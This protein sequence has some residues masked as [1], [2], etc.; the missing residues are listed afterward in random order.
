MQRTVLATM[1]V[2]FGAGCGDQGVVR[3]RPRLALSPQYVDFGGVPVALAA[4]QV[5]RLSN[6]GET[7]LQWQAD[8]VAGVR[9]LSVSRPAGQLRSGESTALEVRLLAR[10]SG[11]LS[12]HL[13]IKTNNPDQPEVLVPVRGQVTPEVLKVSPGL[14]AFGPVRVGVGLQRYVQVQNMSPDRVRLAISVAPPAEGLALLSDAFVVLPAYG[15]LQVDLQYIPDAVG[16]MTSYLHI[17]GDCTRPCQERLAVSGRAVPSSL[18]C[19]PSAVDFSYTNLESCSHRTVACENFGT[20]AIRLNELELDAPDSGMSVDHPALPRT[21]EPGDHVDLELTY[22]PDA[23]RVSSAQ[24]NLHVSEG[25]GQSTVATVGLLGT[26]GGPNISVQPQRIYFG[27]TALGATRVR[28][29]TVLNVGNA[30]LTLSGHHFEPGAGPF[31]WLAPAGPARILA[32]SSMQVSLRFRADTI[33]PLR[34]E[35]VLL[36]DDPDQPETRITLDAE[37][38]EPGRCTA[39]LQPSAY[40]FGLVDVGQTSQATITLSAGATPCRWSDPRV[41]GDSSFRLSHIFARSGEVPAGA[42]VAF[43]IEYHAGAPSSGP[44][45]SA[46]FTIDVPHAQPDE[47]QVDLTAQAT[48]HDLLIWPASIDFGSRQ[49]G[50]TALRALFVF[51]TGTARHVLSTFD[52]QALGLELRPPPAPIHLNPGESLRIDLLWTPQVPALMQSTLS[53]RSNTLPA[54]LRVQIRGNA[55][56]ARCGRLRA[57]ICAPHGGWP[58]VG[59]QVKI[60]TRGGQEFTSE[61]DES[62]A[63]FGSCLPEGPVTVEVTQGHYRASLVGNVYLDRM[64]DLGRVCLSGP[65]AAQ[66]A[67]ISGIYDDVQTVLDAAEVNY[68]VDPTGPGADRLLTDLDLLLSFDV[69]LLACGFPDAL[70]RDPQVAQNLRSFVLQGGSL[71]VSDLGYNALEAAWPEA[72]DFSGDDSV[73]DAANAGLG[74]PVVL[75]ARVLEPEVIRLVGSPRFDVA[76]DLP[77]VRVESTHRSATVVAAARTFGPTAGLKPLA[78]VYRP[79]ATS[80][81]VVFTTVHHH[82]Q[83]SE[84]VQRILQ[85]LI[86]RL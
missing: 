58:A 56:S 51:N 17:E 7:L 55:Q 82:A 22:C 31:E 13:R 86:Y 21:L 74:A 40:S 9:G 50:E 39:S 41:V 1:V 44:G 38:V 8:F 60:Q 81:T 59:A 12:G 57:S 26:G 46:T 15:N 77:Y 32:G 70:A 29:L 54:A 10:E 63:L 23:R 68:V 43:D 34:P 71:Y 62:G 27:A 73:P 6:R 28:T 83:T 52:S 72:I 45:D 18:V 2:C 85:S 79:T 25:D 76:L 49:V 16:E 67:V 36:S 64:T 4:V 20:S 80:G 69:L 66:V 19:D 48:E 37:G 14:V 78:V 61:T 75:Q 24:L 11:P 42:S 53:F 84:S 33:G 47:L 65:P 35:L 3:A 30:A 5:V